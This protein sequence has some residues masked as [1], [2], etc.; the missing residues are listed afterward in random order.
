MRESEIVV[1]KEAESRLSWKFLSQGAELFI[2]VSLSDQPIKLYLMST[3]R[4]L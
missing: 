4:V 3:S 1:R 2:G